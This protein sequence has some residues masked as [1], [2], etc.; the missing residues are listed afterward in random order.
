MII[1]K[2]SSKLKNDNPLPCSIH[3]EDFFYVLRNERWSLPWSLLSLSRLSLVHCQSSPVFIKIFCRSF[4][5][6][7]TSDWRTLLVHILYIGSNLIYDQWMSNIL[8]LT[9]AL[10]CL[11][12]MEAP[13]PEL[14]VHNIKYIIYIV[15]FCIN[16]FIP[17]L[18]LVVY[19]KLPYINKM[20][21]MS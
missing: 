2:I 6:D 9:N 13:E 7:K 8:V 10:V 15:V 11:S 1:I 4:T 12:V 3:I 14:V 16:I 20:V 18:V 17:L 19:N 21:S 5:D